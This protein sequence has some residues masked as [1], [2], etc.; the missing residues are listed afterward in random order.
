M[1]GAMKVGNT[2][3][4][5]WVRIKGFEFESKHFEISTFFGHLCVLHWAQEKNLE[6]YDQDVLMTAASGRHS[7]ILEW[8]CDSGYEIQAKIVARAAARFGQASLLV[9]TKERNLIDASS[10]PELYHFS[11]RGGHINVLDWLYN[12]KYVVC[13]DVIF[14]GAA[15][16]DEQVYNCINLGSRA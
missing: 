2:K 6:W 14:Q 11:S 8:I 5:E 1:K 9:W 4:L 3:V 15:F 7:H 16:G 12:S 10:G 13:H